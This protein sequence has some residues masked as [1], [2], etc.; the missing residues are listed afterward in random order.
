MNQWAHS[1][2]L[3]A[4]KIPCKSKNK[5]SNNNNSN[6]N[7][8]NNTKQSPRRE[9]DSHLA[10][11]EIAGF[12]CSP[13]VHYCGNYPELFESSSHNHILFLQIRF[14]IILP[15]TPRSNRWVK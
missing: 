9:A 13:M 7:N 10:S 14:N 12:F 11:Q 15:S 3:V 6:N 1:L 2:N 4:K 5:H 8:N